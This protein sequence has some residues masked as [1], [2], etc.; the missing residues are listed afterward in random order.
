M[1]LAFD[2]DDTITAMPGLFAALSTAA[3]VDRVIIVSSRMNRPEILHATRKELDGYGVRYDQI[4]LIDDAAVAQER[5]PHPELDWY[6]QYLW[7]KVEICL[8]ERV[9]VVFE[10]DAKVI[11]LFKRYAPAILVLQAHQSERDP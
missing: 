7:Q 6:Q 8:R 5:C 10:D 1:N 9:D 2:I 3:G 4:H 11:A